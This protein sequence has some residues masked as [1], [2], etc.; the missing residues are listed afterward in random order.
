[1]CILD[2]HPLATVR[3][4]DV[5]LSH[6]SVP[7]RRTGDFV[8]CRTVD[9]QQQLGGH[10]LPALFIPNVHSSGSVLMTQ[11]LCQDRCGWRPRMASPSASDFCNPK[12]SASTYPA[13]GHGFG[14]EGDPRATST[15][16]MRIGRI[17]AVHADHFLQWRYQQESRAGK[18]AHSAVLAAIG[19]SRI[20][21]QC[22][23][24][25]LIQRR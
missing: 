13:Y 10:S 23:G 4:T 22:P 11:R 17:S 25:A 9:S 3:L 16:R 24:K 8:S 14:Q 1:M 7:T 18:V 5:Q 12:Q 6:C 19:G 2:H 15:A 20:V 21:P